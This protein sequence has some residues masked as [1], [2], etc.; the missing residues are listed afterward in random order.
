VIFAY[1]PS[2]LL[3]PIGLINAETFDLELH[4][5]AAIIGVLGAKNF[6][7]RGDADAAVN[8][9]VENDQLPTELVFVH[10]KLQHIYVIYEH[11]TEELRLVAGTHPSLGEDKTF[12]YEHEVLSDWF[13]MQEEA[14]LTLLSL[15]A[16]TAEQPE[17]DKLLLRDLEAC[18]PLNPSQRKQLADLV[19]SFL[20]HT[21]EK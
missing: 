13:D 3:D 7:I 5:Q 11:E 1:E 12:Y 15:A 17:D 6:K 10:A 14:L 20:E 9:L 4:H 19:E 2:A 21:E 8:Y 18:F 16:A